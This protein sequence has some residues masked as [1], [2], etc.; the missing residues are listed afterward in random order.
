MIWLIGNKGMLGQELSRTFT[1][2]GTDFTGSDREISILEPEALKQF[3][4]ANQPDWIV[5]CSAYTAVDKAESEEDFAYALNRDGIANIAAVAAERNIPLIHIS[6]DYVFDGS[7][8]VPLTEDAPVGPVSVYGKSKLAGEEALKTVTDRFFIIRTAWLYGQ[9]GPNFVYTMLKL[10][11]CRDSIK[12][13]DDQHGS[14]TWTG[15]LAVL[16]K[17]IIDTQ[18]KDYGVYHFS[19]GGEC[20]WFEFA[21]AI[22]ETGKKTGIIVGDCEI[23]PCTS[24]EFSTPAK[25]PEYSLL[26]KDK[27]TQVFDI[28]VP[29]WSTSLDCFFDKVQGLVDKVATWI[30]HAEYDLETA[31]AMYTSGRFLYV[32]ITCQQSIE[33]MFKAVCEYQE[34]SVPRIHDLLRLYAHLFPDQKIEKIELLKDLS[35]YYIAARYGERVKKLSADLNKQHADEII[36]QSE[37]MCKWLKSMIPFV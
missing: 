29:E 11:N 2:A 1:R 28:T 4:D 14:P 13:V 10:M 26:S 32:A 27:V 18:S 17:T 30:E 16:I 37:D 7:S 24:S 5:N 36:S 15:E 20:T 21:K 25:R 33:K 22:Y 19:G 6:T 23:N 12:V 35:F 9:Y 3:A 8:T 31:R 34:I